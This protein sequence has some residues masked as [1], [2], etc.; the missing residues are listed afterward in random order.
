MSIPSGGGSTS[1]YRAR[2]KRLRAVVA[3]LLFLPWATGCY[4]YVPLWQGTPR[5]GTLVAVGL[6]DRGRAELANRIGP[7]VRQLTGRV[8]TLSDSSLT[9]AVS[10]VTYIGP[11]AP[12]TWNGEMVVIPREVVSGIQERRLS[13][14][15][16]WIAA[17]AAV[18]AIALIS[19]IAIAGFGSDPP[20]DKLPGGSNP[21]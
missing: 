5:A 9:L 19:T 21:Q 16:S 7:G 14:S 1:G 3:G 10:S 4:T 17:G 20:S 6:S 15:R 12:M 18:A 2:P 13:K 11:G 8:A